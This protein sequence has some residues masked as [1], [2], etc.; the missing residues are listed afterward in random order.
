MSK[1]FIIGIGYVM[2]RFHFERCWMILKFILNFLVLHAGIMFFAKGMIEYKIA[3]PTNCGACKLQEA[4]A[5]W[6]DAW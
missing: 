2:L 5:T 3:G 4:G 6:Q 1:V